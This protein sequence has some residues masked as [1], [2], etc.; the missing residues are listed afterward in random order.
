MLSRAAPVVSKFN[1]AFFNVLCKTTITGTGLGVV[2]GSTLSPIAAIKVL[3]SAAPST[4]ASE[5]A[6][7]AMA[8]AGKTIVGAAAIGFYVGTAPV[9]I[10]IK[11]AV[12]HYLNSHKPI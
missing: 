3:E 6:T 4:P 8:A 2:V 11:C 10:P 7:K 1:G 12:D 9:S 5:V